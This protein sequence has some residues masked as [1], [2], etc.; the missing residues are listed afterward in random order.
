MTERYLVAAQRD[1]ET[2]VGTYAPGARFVAVLLHNGRWELE[3]SLPRNGIGSR[4]LTV[5]ADAV[6]CGAELPESTARRVA[7][8]GDYRFARD[9]LRMGHASALAWLMRSYG[10]GE[11]TLLRWGFA[12]YELGRW[13]S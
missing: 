6:A 12:Q 5:P 8:H 4:I 3:L 10:I 1:I 2:V 9:V 13:A 7:A 11:R